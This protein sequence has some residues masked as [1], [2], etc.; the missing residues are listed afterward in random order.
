M[1]PIQVGI[2]ALIILL[3]DWLGYVFIK[4]FSEATPGYG[5]YGWGLYI[6]MN[7]AALIYLKQKYLKG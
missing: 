5:I 6:A 2:D 1:N 7:A 4:T 3:F